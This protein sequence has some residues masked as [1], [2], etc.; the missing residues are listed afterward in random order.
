MSVCKHIDR[1]ERTCR[2]YKSHR[3]VSRHIRSAREKRHNSEEVAQEYEEERRQQVWSIFPILR[4]YRLLDYII[5]D[6]HDH[7]FHKPSEASGRAFIRCIMRTV[8]LCCPQHQSD[9]KKGREYKRS[10]ILGYG[11]IKRPCDGPVRSRFHY[12]VFIT[13]FLRYRESFVR[14]SMLDFR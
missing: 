12:L 5:I 8:P 6:H 11:Y 3:Y 9:Q 2:Q 13:S 14:M 4:S 1:K 10:H 7:H